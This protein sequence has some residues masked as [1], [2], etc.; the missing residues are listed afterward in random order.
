[1]PPPNEAAVPTNANA[2]HDMGAPEEVGC[3]AHRSCPFGQPL[4]IGAG[5][6][7]WWRQAW[8]P[9]STRRFA[10]ENERTTRVCEQRTGL[11]RKSNSCLRS[12]SREEADLRG[13][14]CVWRRFQPVSWCQVAPMVGASQ[15]GVAGAGPR[16]TVEMDRG[17]FPSQT[18]CPSP[19]RPGKRAQTVAL[20]SSGISLRG[21][22]PA[23]PAGPAA[24]ALPIRSTILSSASRM[25]VAIRAFAAPASPL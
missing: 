14:F 5:Q 25:S 6:R 4:I 13:F 20:G 19:Q 3:R 18:I 10:N 15:W 7:A 9:A 24:W 2:S 22:T 17:V 1:M 21:V 12:P 8:S 16:A 11:L 23:R